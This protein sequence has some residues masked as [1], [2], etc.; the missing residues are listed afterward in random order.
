MI[1]PV[2]GLGGEAALE[3]CPYPLDGY[4]NPDHLS[5]TRRG[6][7]KQL[8]VTLLVAFEGE[9]IPEVVVGA[10]DVRADGRV[11]DPWEGTSLEIEI[12]GRRDVYMDQHMQWNLPWSAG[13]YTGEGRLFHS[14]LRKNQR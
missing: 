12:N 7:G 8:L 14:R 3:P 4:D 13:G 6:P 5:Y 9:E 10:I 2:P 1:V 11:L